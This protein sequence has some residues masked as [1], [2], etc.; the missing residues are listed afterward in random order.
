M[1]SI[2]NWMMICYG[3]A[4]IADAL[5]YWFIQLNSINFKRSDPCNSRLDAASGSCYEKIGFS[6]AAK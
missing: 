2:A 5:F 3:I 6:Q 1:S 4:A